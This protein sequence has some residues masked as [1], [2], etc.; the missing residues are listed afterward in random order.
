MAAPAQDDTN[1]AS[2]APALPEPS[3]FEWS[4]LDPEIPVPA[5]KAAPT[6]APAMLPGNAASWKRTDQPGGATMLTVKQTVL[7]FWDAHVGADLNIAAR[8]PR[9][10]SEALERKLAGEELSRSNGSAWANLTAPGLGGLW[11][12]TT[13]AARLDPAD[14]NRIGTSI[15]KSLPL[16]SPQTSLTLQGGYIVVDQSTL[17]PLIGPERTVEVGH[18]ARLSFKDTGTSLI[19]GETSSSADDIWLSHVGVEQKIFGAVSIAASVSETIEGPSD[20]RL[21]ASFRQSW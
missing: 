13:I 1:A 10:S 8:G 4:L 17:L 21:T 2:A 15:S 11:D 20:Q 3:A 14:S 9:T 19:A 5:G 16:G 6:R 7:P 18:S 12:K